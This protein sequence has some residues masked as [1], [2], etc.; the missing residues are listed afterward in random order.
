[1]PYQLNGT[2][3]LIICLEILEDLRSQLLGEPGE[4]IA[5]IKRSGVLVP[6]TPLPPVLESFEG[7][8]AMAQAKIDLLSRR[9]IQRGAVDEAV[10]V[11]QGLV[12]E[13]SKAPTL[14]ERLAS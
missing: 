2:E 8:E 10:A 5:A 9:R 1:M 12:R 6:S 3:H 14:C 11:I 7:R 4:A 13:L